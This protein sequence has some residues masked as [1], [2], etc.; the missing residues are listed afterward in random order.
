MDLNI[1]FLIYHR[2]IKAETYYLNAY[3]ATCRC[4]GTVQLTHCVAHDVHSVIE[5]N[6]I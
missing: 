4:V 1:D 3:A 5:N 2:Y 6:T